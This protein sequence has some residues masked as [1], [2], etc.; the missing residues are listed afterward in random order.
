[1]D[2]VKAAWDFYTRAIALD[3]SFVNE[4][5]E[6]RYK[7][8]TTSAPNTDG[9]SLQRVSKGEQDSIL[10]LY[11]RAVSLQGN[12]EKQRALALYRA[13][14]LL[15]STHVRTM[16]NMGVLFARKG[17]Y[18]SAFHYYSRVLRYEPGMTQ[19]Y[20]NLISVQLMRGDSAQAREIFARLKTLPADSAL[21]EKA[22]EL[23]EPAVIR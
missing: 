5:I 1:M 8:V 19:T 4:D 9:S 12:G 16:N 17:A 10:A 7:T 18:D 6:K 21:L 14:L 15:D 22:V 13:I 11:N 2:S 3:S 23:F 20:V